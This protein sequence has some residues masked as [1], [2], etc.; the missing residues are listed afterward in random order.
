MR[1]ANYVPVRDVI[2]E[3]RVALESNATTKID[4]ITFVGSGETLLHA[5]IGWMLRAVKD[6]TDIPVAVITNGSLLYQPYVRWELAVADAV[7]P[8]LDAGND[9]LYHRLNRAH[10]AASFSL[11]RDGLVAFRNGYLGQLWIEVMLVHGL[12]DG[13][14]ELSE[15]AS[16]LR[17]IRPD[18]IHING[19]SRSSVESWVKRP[20]A[21]TVLRAS[22]VFGNVAPT[23]VVRSSEGVCELP[24]DQSVVDAVVQVVTRHPLRR[25]DLE[26]ALARLE[27]H[28]VGRNMALL[29]KSNQLQVV[30]R[31]GTEYWVS[32]AAFFPENGNGATTFV[33]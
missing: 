14:T 8:S 31:D 26:N 19:P 27:P 23:R 5:K 17:Q 13:E 12:N 2:D 33:A 22:R 4:W 7:L 10:R 29:E 15:I 24:T 6:L 3:V 21:D 11:H 25:S 1:R 30:V 32:A 28:E 18:Q 16:L 9:S 20:D